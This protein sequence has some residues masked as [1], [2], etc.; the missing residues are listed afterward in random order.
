MKAERRHELQENSLIRGVRNF[1][2]FW[3]AYGSKILLGII[4]ILLAILLI[5]MWIN[6]RADARRAMAED[7]YGGRAMLE[8]LRHQQEI[9]PEDPRMARMNPDAVGMKPEQVAQKRRETWTRV[10]AAVANVLQNSSDAA[11]LAE[12]KLL[13]ADLNYHFGLLA[14]LGQV[15]GANKDRGIEETPE[16]YF[17]RA[18]QNYTE[19]INQAAAIQPRQVAAARLGMAAVHENRKQFAEARALYELVQKEGPDDVSRMQAANHLHVLAMIKPDQ[20][21]S[22]QTLS[23]IPPPARKPTSL[24][25]QPTTGASTQPASTQPTTKPTTATAPATA[26]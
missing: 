23:D 11:Q 24:P 17:D 19:V 10:D 8:N 18:G 14:T 16:Q 7:L 4:L 12:A 2:E 22:T 6:K 13:K 15:S 26:P 21:I 3:R 20:Y 5:R 1:P 9:A 25:T